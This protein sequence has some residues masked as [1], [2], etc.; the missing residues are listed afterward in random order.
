MMREVPEGYHVRF[1]HSRILQNT[2][3]K[4]LPSPRG[5]RTYCYL[6][7]ESNV[8]VVTGVA[9]CSKE[10]Q[11]NKKIGRAISLGRALKAYDEY[12]R[13]EMSVA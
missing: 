3:P 4:L 10:D 8:P 9:Y 12:V 13:E 5:G 7:D 6:E 1:Q 11:Y 2:F